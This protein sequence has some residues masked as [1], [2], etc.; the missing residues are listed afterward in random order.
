MKYVFNYLHNLFGFVFYYEDTTLLVSE[1][2][3]LHILSIPLERSRY[4]PIVNS[5]SL[6]EFLVSF[7]TSVKKQVWFI[8]ILVFKKA[9]IVQIVY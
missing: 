4:I 3:V 6:I 9:N 1:L 7:V 2:S 8:S 5:L